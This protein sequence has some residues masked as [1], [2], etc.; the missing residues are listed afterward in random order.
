M[1]VT[2]NDRLVPLNY[3]SMAASEFHDKN[4]FELYSQFLKPSLENFIPRFRRDQL[5]LGDLLGSGSFNDVFALERIKAN[6]NVIDRN[7]RNQFAV[8]LLK[9]E[10]MENE[11]DYNNGVADLV[12]ETKILA[13]L[14][15]HPNLIRIHGTSA[16]EA[17]N[18]FPP[19]LK[20]EY[21]II[22]DRLND[23]LDQRMRSWKQRTTSLQQRLKAATDLCSALA[24]VHKSN[25]LFRDLKPANVGF[26]IKGTLKLFDF[27]MAIEL[28]PN[29]RNC[30]ESYE[31]SGET[32]SRRYMAPE[33]A[34]HQTYNLSADVYSFGVLLW[35]VCSLEEP[36]E[37]MD[38]SDHFKFVVQ[39]N[40]R[41]IIHPDWP[42]KL[43]NIMKWCWA[44]DKN[45]RP[46]IHHILRALKKQLSSIQEQPENSRPIPVRSSSERLCRE[47]IL[48][49]SKALH[50][51]LLSINTKPFQTSRI[52]PVTP[53]TQRDRRTRRFSLSP[54]P[55]FGFR[56]RNGARSA[57]KTVKR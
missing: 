23:T 31:L 2:S 39:G 12:M 50:S 25:V 49:E 37:G 1:D 15:P 52:T 30:D 34:L 43:V 32:G 36:Y 19:E 10:L 28:D 47:K 46:P 6:E 41:P 13:N 4:E 45:I 51:S 18:T 27:G 20:G 57:K 33:V 42:S 55:F 3:L 40:E 17:T 56:R 16:E 8:K 44:P 38:V 14:E 35:E 24:H 48:Q 54:S 21:V 29:E 5:V 53:N 22:V 11:E 7:I 9:R 26:D